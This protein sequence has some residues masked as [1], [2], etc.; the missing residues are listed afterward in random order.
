MDWDDL[1]HIAHLEREIRVLESRLQPSDTGHIHTA[2]S[3]LR[4][5]VRE[6]SLP[7]ATDLNGDGIDL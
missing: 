3:V 6:L 2:I 7:F 4:D 1:E 5:R